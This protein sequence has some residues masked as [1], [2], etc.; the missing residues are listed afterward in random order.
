MYK[1]ISLVSV[2]ESTR[3]LAWV[4]RKKHE[5]NL[6]RRTGTSTELPALSTHDGVDKNAV[7]SQNGKLLASQGTLDFCRRCSSTKIWA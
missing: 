2:P 4:E 5:G 3:S 7:R 6:R 1:Y